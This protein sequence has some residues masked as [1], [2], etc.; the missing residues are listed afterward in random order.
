M[1]GT[2]SRRSASRSHGDSLR[3]RIDRKSTRLNSS[4]T[5]I[6]YAVFCLKKKKQ[7]D[8][9][10]LSREHTHEL[11]AQSGRAGLLRLER[12]ISS[13]VDLDHYL[14]SLWTSCASDSQN[15]DGH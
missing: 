6:S 15:V 3:K 9:L 14:D 12:A 7:C 4:H 1:F 5:V 10:L 2:R 11:Y 13:G 8:F